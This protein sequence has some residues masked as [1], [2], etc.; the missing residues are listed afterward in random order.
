MVYHNKSWPLC[1]NIIF[2]ITLSIIHYY[3]PSDSRVLYA[4]GFCY[5]TL[6]QTETAKKVITIWYN[7]LFIHCLCSFFSVINVPLLCKSLKVW[8]LLN[9]QSKQEREMRKRWHF[10]PNQEHFLWAPA[11]THNSAKQPGYSL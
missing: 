6:E 2:F 1:L 9:L 4:L 7:Y 10:N 3:R 11:S 5:D 8:L